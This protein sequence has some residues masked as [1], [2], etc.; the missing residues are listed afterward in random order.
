MITT[1]AETDS[2]TLFNFLPVR[3]G[4]LRAANQMHEP[5][6]RDRYVCIYSNIKRVR[7]VGLSKLMAHDHYGDGTYNPIVK[8]G[9]KYIKFMDNGHKPDYC[10][11]IY[12]CVRDEPYVKY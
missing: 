9:K 3:D 12:V 10:V 6:D 7:N 1:I 11:C 2:K 5:E 8:K 4:E